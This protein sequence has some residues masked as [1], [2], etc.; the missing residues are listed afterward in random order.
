VDTNTN[1]NLNPNI[2]LTSEDEPKEVMGIS[3]ES[4][5]SGID[6]KVGANT[7]TGYI[8]SQSLSDPT[9]RSSENTC[10]IISICCCSIVNIMTIYMFLYQPFIWVD[11][12]IARFM[13]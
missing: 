7:S 5:G 9:T 12:S 6:S 1:T 10:Y 2:T 11:G 3:V 13:Y 8:V 4:C